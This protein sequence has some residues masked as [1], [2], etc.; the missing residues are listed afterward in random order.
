MHLVPAGNRS[1]LWVLETRQP[2]KIIPEGGKP[3]KLMFSEEKIEPHLKTLFSK[4]GSIPDIDFP[5]GGGH[6]DS[7]NQQF[8]KTFLKI[9]K[10]MD[11]WD[12]QCA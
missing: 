2:S 10:N 8:Q 11:L 4:W 12:T 1:F 6:L 3:P 9:I 5:I 7:Q